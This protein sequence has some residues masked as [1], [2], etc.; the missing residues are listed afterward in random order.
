MSSEIISQYPANFR[1]ECREVATQLKQGAIGLPEACRRL[2][3]LDTKYQAKL[4]GWIAKVNADVQ[5][6]TPNATTKGISESVAAAREDLQQAAR[7]VLPV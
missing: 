3:A 4:D 1:I 6:G 7:K 5:R 2:I